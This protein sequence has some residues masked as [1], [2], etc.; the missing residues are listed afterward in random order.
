MAVI[1]V[2]WSG[3]G[4]GRRPKGQVFG[5]QRHTSGH[6][7]TASA[8]RTSRVRL[9]AGTAV[10]RHDGGPLSIAVIFCVFPTA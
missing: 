8:A 4:Y 9:P 2:K 5:M 3:D 7:T 10:G 6:A 1:P